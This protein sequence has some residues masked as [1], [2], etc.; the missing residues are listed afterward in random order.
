[1]AIT[2]CLF[3]KIVQK[4]IPSE[5]V[6]EDDLCIAINDIEPCCPVHILI[7]PKQHIASLEEAKNQDERL[8]GHI[9][10]VAAKIARGKGI[11]GQ[12]YRLVCNCGEWG[13]QAV[14]HLHYHLLGGKELGWPPE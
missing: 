9:Q 5:I 7:M 3:C 4:K 13:G 2:E 6:Y 1:M 12:G 11:A 8:L 14:F 10:L